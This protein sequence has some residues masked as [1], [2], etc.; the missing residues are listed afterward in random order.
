MKNWSVS[1]LES[2]NGP[3]DVP[4]FRASGV[5]CDIRGKQNDRLDIGILFSEKPC[6]VA[7]VFTTNKVRAAPVTLCEE[8]LASGGA[9]HGV[10]A[11]SG[12][13][14]ACTG[15]EGWANALRMVAL[16]ESGLRLKADSMLVCSTG[17]IGRQMPM[18]QVEKGIEKAIGSLG[19]APA[20]G[21]AFADCILT[22]D[23]RNK[24]ITVVVSDGTQAIT[25]AGVAKGAGMIR[26]DMATMLAFL[27]TDIGIDRGDLKNVLKTAADQT[28]N[29]ITVDGDMST[30]DTVLV[31]ANG[32]SG[33]R[34]SEL[35]IEG[36][37]AFEAGLLKV[38]EH[39]AYL[40][41]G[42]GE[43]ITKVVTLEISGA[44]DPAAAKKVGYAIA[45]SALVKSSWA[46]ED[47]NWG[48]ILA[49]AGYSGVAVDERKMDLHYDQV[50]VWIKGR[51][52]E[53]NLSK[54]KEVVSQES[55]RI[56]LDLGLGNGSSRILASDLTP[57]YITYNMK[58]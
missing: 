41:V 44:P 37:M 34:Y 53:E 21:L 31:F 1:V 50:P 17:R 45:H 18:A 5:G 7:G 46:G 32:H 25:I 29:A 54:W 20:N 38:C 3:T 19:N 42:D 43:K 4:G 16:A 49:A 33:I 48:R 28:F 47:P 23:T 35:S 52:C 55:F 51:I 10:V 26:P 6:S 27:A 22:S 13:A 14:N 39:L 12:N 30:N 36:K 24:K 56:H 2:I 15:E 57:E 40:I 9:I 8:R 58:E 11:N